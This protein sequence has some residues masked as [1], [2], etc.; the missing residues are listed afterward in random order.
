MSDTDEAMADVEKGKTREE[1]EYVPAEYVA[2]AEADEHAKG[3][4]RWSQV[5]D[6][7]LA[8]REALEVFEIKSIKEDA[9]CVKFNPLCWLLVALITLINILGKIVHAPADQARQLRTDE[10]ALERKVRIEWVYALQCANQ[11]P[12]RRGGPRV[13]PHAINASARWRFTQVPHRWRLCAQHNHVLAD[14]Y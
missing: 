12:R 3:G 13:D 5:C 8:F 10:T 4:G 1:E 2:A 11:P 9:C 6:W 7:P 14:P